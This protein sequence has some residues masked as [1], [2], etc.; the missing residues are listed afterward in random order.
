M[1]FRNRKDSESD[2]DEFKYLNLNESPIKTGR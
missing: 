1:E 2:E